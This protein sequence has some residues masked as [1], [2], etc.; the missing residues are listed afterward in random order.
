MPSILRLIVTRIGQICATSGLTGFARELQ[1]FANDDAY[2][3]ALGTPDAEHPIASHAFIPLGMFAA[4]M[5]GEGGD[6]AGGV[7]APT[8]PPC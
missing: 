5:S 4:S 8:R 2:Y 6:A 1:A 7:S 3:A